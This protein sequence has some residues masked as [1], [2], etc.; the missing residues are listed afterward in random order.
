MR[1]ALVIFSG[2]GLVPEVILV[3]VKSYLRACGSEGGSEMI[4]VEEMRKWK[5]D[6]GEEINE[7]ILSAL[8]DSD[9]S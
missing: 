5:V 1:I 7:F 2:G 9:E 4:E 8:H 6:I 3:L